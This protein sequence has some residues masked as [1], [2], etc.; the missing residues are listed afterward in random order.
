MVLAVDP[1]AWEK[2][3]LP[4]PSAH[5]QLP[6]S[7][8]TAIEKKEA[9]KSVA[10]VQGARGGGLLPAP[11]QPNPALPCPG[12]LLDAS[13]AHAHAQHTLGPMGGPLV[14]WLAVFYV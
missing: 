10:G 13:A 8:N 1:R 12:S 3:L 5:W 14:G 4:H 11:F 7:A 6:R 2:L 9:S